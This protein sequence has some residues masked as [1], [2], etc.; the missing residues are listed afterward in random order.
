MAGNQKLFSC[1]TLEEWQTALVSYKDVM[2]EKAKLLTKTPRRPRGGKDLIELDDWF[3][4]DLPIAIT[5]RDEKH[6]T[7]E[8]LCKLMKW[9]LMRGKFRPRLTELVQANKP[10]EVIAASKKAFKK[11]PNISEAI[12]ALI[13]LKAVGPATASA[14]LAAG[15]PE[16]APFMADESML[17]IPGLQPLQ[18]TLNHYVSYVAQIES[19]MERLNK[20]DDMVEWS[21]HDVELALWTYHM[22]KQLDINIEKSGQKRKSDSSDTSKLKKQ[23]SKSKDT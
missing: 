11:L 9:K 20:E 17:A 19:C 23:K 4:N 7:H 22:A 5:S 8:E 16:V 15:A 3:Q 21:A 10:E 6:I 1:G 14:V 18:Y 2:K 13:V 12:K